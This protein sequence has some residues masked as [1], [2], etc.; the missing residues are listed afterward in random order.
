[1][2]VFACDTQHNTIIVLFEQRHSKIRR[3]HEIALKMQGELTN[4]IMVDNQLSDLV[5]IVWV[6]RR[7]ITVFD[8]ILVHIT[9]MPRMIFGSLRFIR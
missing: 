6:I 4:G 1:M 5:E 7:V 2:D 9:R 3:E 8:S